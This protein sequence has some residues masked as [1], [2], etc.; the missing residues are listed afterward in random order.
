MMQ[1]QVE[2]SSLWSMLE[3]CLNCLV[4]S[5]TATFLETGCPR[6]RRPWRALPRPPK[7]HHCV[8]QAW[9]GT[10]PATQ[11]L[12]IF[13]LKPSEGRNKKHQQSF[14]QSI[15]DPCTCTV[16]IT[17]GPAPCHSFQ[18]KTY[19]PLLFFQIGSIGDGTQTQYTL[20]V[21]SSC[22]R[23]THVAAHHQGMACRVKLSHRCDLFSD[24]AAGLCCYVWAVFLQ[25][26]HPQIAV[27]WAGVMK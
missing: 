17:L 5:A 21:H 1:T 20:I 15:Y 22:M 10:I 16:S 8:A 27:F 25:A 9:P 26:A 2:Y 4:S 23:S 14:L 7:H 6:K 11:P 24:A 12:H 18:E 3:D 13:G 19:R